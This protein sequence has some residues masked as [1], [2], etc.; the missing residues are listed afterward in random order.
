[1]GRFDEA[2]EEANRAEELDPQS[3]IINTSLGWILY[4]ARRYDEAM[5]EL[6]KTLEMDPNFFLA[7]Q[8][9]WQTYVQKGMYDEALGG[10]ELKG[11]GSEESR[12]RDEIL[13]KAYDVSGWKGFRRKELELDTERS[14]AT[15][16]SS[17][18]ALA[19]VYAEIGDSDLAVKSLEKAYEARE[20]NMVWLK[21]DPFLDGVRSDPRFTDLLRR[22]R[23][24]P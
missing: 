17:D 18:L 3:L 10:K 6:R 14:R 5:E 4:L 19:P 13:R 20:V 22:M 11:L 8:L 12:E 15:G 16:V 7:Q 9:L 1:M 23:L 2:V 24:E 21:V